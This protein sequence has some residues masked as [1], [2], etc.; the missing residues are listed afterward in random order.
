M[1]M[2]AISLPRLCATVIPFFRPDG[3]V[4]D[5][6][7]PEPCEIDFNEVAYGLAKLARFT[8]TYTGPAYSI[9][10]HSVMGAEALLREGEDEFMASLFLLHDGHEYKLGDDSRPKQDLLFQMLE[11]FSPSSASAFRD[12]M[13]RAK[14][15]WDCAIYSAAGLPSPDAW[16]KKQQKTI[17]T[18]DVR[19]AAAEAQAL[20]GDAARKVYPASKYPAPLTRGA[21]TPWG[22]AQAEIRFLECFDRLI[23]EKQRKTAT[24]NHLM[25]R[26]GKRA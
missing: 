13:H 18:M 2:T 21:I 22:Q 5:L 26:K 17:A 11:D 1:P 9:A 20:F 12:V 10:Q 3:S 14:A 7:K 25:H 6:A 16:T 23:G 4:T 19:M 8:G 15:G 24:N